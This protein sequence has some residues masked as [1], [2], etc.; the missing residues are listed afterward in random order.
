VRFPHIVPRRVLLLLLAAAAL[1][2]CR[3]EARAPANVI[4]RERFVAANVALRTLPDSAPQS[5][6]DAT[7]RKNRVTER[8]LR[9]WVTLHSRDPRVL[10]SAWEEIAG[11]V[12]SIGGAAPAAQV[13]GEPE[14]PPSAGLPSSRDSLAR[15][16]PG[17]DSIFDSRRPRRPPPPARVKPLI[18]EAQ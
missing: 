15:A 10:A 14:L 6:R 16:R 5:V 11:K 1:G 4:S 18:Q 17:M 9:T 13:P 12:D 3:R 7:L 2:G 8:Q